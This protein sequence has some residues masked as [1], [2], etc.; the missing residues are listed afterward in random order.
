MNMPWG[1]A[2]IWCDHAFPSHP[3]R[4]AHAWDMYPHVAIECSG[5][6]LVD[7]IE[8]QAPSGSIHRVWQVCCVSKSDRGFTLYHIDNPYV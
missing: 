8:T 4:F 5:R 1:N 6:R 7:G 3:I 2:S